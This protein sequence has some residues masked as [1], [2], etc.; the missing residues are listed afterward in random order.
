M[1]THTSQRP[2]HYVGNRFELSDPV[3]GL[4]R[5]ISSVSLFVGKFSI[6]SSHITNHK[7]RK[8]CIQVIAFCGQLNTQSSATQIEVKTLFTH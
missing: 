1:S 6:F 4:L 3:D 7:N 2:A 5:N 8:I